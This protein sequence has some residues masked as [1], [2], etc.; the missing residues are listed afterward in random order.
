MAREVSPEVYARALNAAESLKR[1]LEE[2]L[3][4]KSAHAWSCSCGACG[5]GP[6]KVVGIDMPTTYQYQ[7]AMW[8][9]WTCDMKDDKGKGWGQGIS[10]YIPRTELYPMFRNHFAGNDVRVDHPY[11]RLYH[12]KV[13]GFWGDQAA[14]EGRKF[15]ASG[16]TVVIS[17]QSAAYVRPVGD[18]TNSVWLNAEIRIDSNLEQYATREPRL[19]CNVDPF[20]FGQRHGRGAGQYYNLADP[21]EM[22]TFYIRIPDDGHGKDV[23]FP[24]AR[25]V[26][27]NK[28]T[29]EATF[30]LDQSVESFKPTAN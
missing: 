23:Y 5:A 17:D 12:D 27:V 21:C 11:A 28:S 1:Q 24:I 30:E 22:A 16:R 19:A 3:I 20:E 14:E 4:G 10:T 26:S 25:L 13:N 7:I 9:L 18:L 29:G 8:Q 15:T 2:R 6:S